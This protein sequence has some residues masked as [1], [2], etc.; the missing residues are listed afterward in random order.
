MAIIED[1]AAEA[2][3]RRLRE[4]IA[5]APVTATYSSV[6]K[7]AQDLAHQRGEDL[8]PVAK[9]EMPWA[10]THDSSTAADANEVKP[11]AS[12]NIQGEQTPLKL[13][14]AAKA[15]LD[16]VGKMKPPPAPAKK[17]DDGGDSTEVEMAAKAALEASAKAWPQDLAAAFKGHPSRRDAAIAKAAE[18]NETEKGSTG[19]DVRAQTKEPEPTDRGK[20]EGGAVPVREVA[21]QDQ[22]IDMRGVAKAVGPS[23]DTVERAIRAALNLRYPPKPETGNMCGEG[24]WPREVYVDSVVYCYQDTLYSVPYIFDGKVA[25]LGENPVQVRVSYVPA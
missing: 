20:V 9:T 6:A 7:A 22:A 15:A 13:S 21:K 3:A 10:T 8:I 14:A 4:R 18:I 16:L 1:V 2:K 19:D 12:A 23:F 11:N 24:P 17:D 25:M 5:P